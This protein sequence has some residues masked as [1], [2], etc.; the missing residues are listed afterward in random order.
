MTGPIAKDETDQVAQLT[1]PRD[2]ADRVG[3]DLVGRVD[4]K[5]TGVHAAE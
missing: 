5:P 1:A 4:V 2:R 3:E